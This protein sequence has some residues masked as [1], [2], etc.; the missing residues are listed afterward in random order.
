MTTL[1]DA[2]KIAICESSWGWLGLADYSAILFF[3]INIRYKI[4]SLR[5]FGNVLCSK[6]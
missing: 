2:E 1:R 4:E 3:N 5:L 6:N